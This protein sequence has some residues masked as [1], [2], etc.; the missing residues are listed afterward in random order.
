M[1]GFTA[2]ELSFSRQRRSSAETINGEDLDADAITA[3]FSGSSILNV[4]EVSLALES[5]SSQS[6]RTT[7]SL[8][9]RP[10]STPSADS[11][12]TSFPR[13]NPSTTPPS[14]TTLPRVR[15]TT[16]PNPPT[17]Q[18]HF[19]HVH[20]H[21]HHVVDPFATL[22]GTVNRGIAQVTGYSTLP[23][24]A[25]N[26]TIVTNQT[27]SF[28]SSTSPIAVLNIQ[29]ESETPSA[30]VKAT[31]A[32]RITEHLKKLCSSLYNKGF[33]AGLF[34][35][36]QY[37]ESMLEGQSWKEVEERN[38]Y[39]QFDDP[40]ISC[41]A[42]ETVF[43]RM[44]GCTDANIHTQNACQL[45]ATASFFHDIDLV[46]S[47]VEFIVSD[48]TFNTVL[49][50][51]NF[52]GHYYGTGTETITDGC[53]TFL[54]R[55][56]YQI[57]NQTSDLIDS[58]QIENSK[59]EN[60]KNI[61]AEMPLAWV[62]RILSADCFYVPNEYA[63]YCFVKEIV[64]RRKELYN[65]DKWSDKA[66]SRKLS[67]VSAKISEDDVLERFSDLDMSD[68]SLDSEE[69]CYNNLF[70]YAVIFSHLTFEELLI[71][72]N[73]NLVS[74]SILQQCLWKQSEFR[75]LIES[76]PL[77]QSELGIQYEIN[78][79]KDSGCNE[80][81]QTMEGIFV[82]ADDTDKIDGKRLSD[83]LRWPLFAHVKVKFPPFR[84]SVEF[85]DLKRLH[86][87]CRF[88]SKTMNYAGS[89]WVIYLQ[90]IVVDQPKLGIYLQRWQ[91]DE[92]PTMLDDSN[93][94]SISDPMHMQRTGD[95]ATISSIP[96][97]DKRIE[98][99]TWFKLYCFFSSKCYV[100]ES[101]PDVFKNTQSWGW[102]SAKLYK[103]AFV[104][105]A[106]KKED[107]LRCCVVMGHI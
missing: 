99:R 45:M 67:A 3:R 65:S 72:R 57:I 28:D 79:R 77:N 54:C 94:F 50:Y 43:S 2:D 13:N 34:S 49:Q 97:I 35:D 27:E 21:V 17:S 81:F 8:R 61:F 56:G 90:K 31:S 76:A 38:L 15:A 40:Y 6:L 20:H 51:L 103:D 82:P 14:P 89:L 24:I 44:Y 86:G 59:A 53:F 37:F 9:R 71:I 30:T 29:K 41:E 62:E 95:N 100:L 101:K 1:I 75:N 87:G 18:H 80:S 11:N 23:P 92:A 69:E 91:S 93:N 98:T 33:K 25:P 47:V 42:L 106:P 7:S 39:L 52:A 48:I 78:D 63:R 16:S 104:N 46:D 60:M 66:P 73:D 107:V 32:T 12:I 105:E 74:E 19:H 68:F 85:E 4:E 55:E 84:F 88:Y 70:S 10:H 83:L 96:Y 26:R 36:N 102:R 22:P 58:P 64:A 5:S